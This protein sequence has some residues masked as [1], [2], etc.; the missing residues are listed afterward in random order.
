MPELP[1]VETIRRSLLPLLLGQEIL[2]L[3]AFT[4][5]VWQ[6]PCELEPLET[7]IIGLSRYG[8]YLKLDLAAP[9]VP[10]ITEAITAETTS[11]SE[12]AAPNDAITG[13]STETTTNSTMAATR[14]TTTAATMAEATVAKPS[15]YASGLLIHLRMTGKLIYEEPNTHDN[16]GNFDRNRSPHRRLEFELLDDS[17]RK[18]RLLFDDIRRFGRIYCLDSE[19]IAVPASYRELG[20]DGLDPN[21]DLQALC[22]RWQKHPKLPLKSLLLR[23]DLLAGLGNIYADEA[24]FRARLNPLRLT[25]SCSHRELLRLA[26]VIQPLLTEAIGLGGTSFR[27]Y[28]DGL[29]RKGNF[30][31]KLGVY[32]RTGL[33]CFHCASAIVRTVIGGRSSHYCPRCQKKV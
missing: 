7:R 32:Q 29:G 16:S 18:S 1:E 2:S 12:A 33:P 24:L 9:K 5:E 6:N 23:Q 25:G 13:T 10:A 20:P 3:R 17:K 28:V 14:D 27:D 31:V 19:N 22:Y 21:L 11:A 8:K 26:E 4:P 30:V 15:K